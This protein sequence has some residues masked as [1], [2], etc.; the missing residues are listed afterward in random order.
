[1]ISSKDPGCSATK[2]GCNDATSEF[3]AQ[4]LQG[5]NIVSQS[6]V[7]PF[8][9][10]NRCGHDPKVP[11]KYTYASSKNKKR[12]P[13]IEKCLR[14]LEVLYKNP[15]AHDFGKLT[16]HKGKVIKNGRFRRV[17]SEAREAL[18]LLATRWIISHVNLNNKIIGFFADNK[19]FIHYDLVR[20]Q[21]NTGISLNQCKKVIRILREN[22]YITV[23]RFA[24]KFEGNRYRPRFTIIKVNDSLFYDLGLTLQEVERDHLNSIKRD[25]YFYMKPKK[26]IKLAPYN[27][28]IEMPGHNRRR[29][30]DSPYQDL[31]DYGRNTN[32]NPPQNRGE[33]PLKHILDILKKSSIQ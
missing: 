10:G 24:E 27:K 17:R 12:P 29:R 7:Q 5:N 28:D 25:N 16:F 2:F 19:T 21:R 8:I 32:T 14:N 31:K 18:L 22:G 23:E 11:K 13:I 15:Y 3:P 30:E 20:M 33:S 4:K 26:K 9:F 6:Y 1:M